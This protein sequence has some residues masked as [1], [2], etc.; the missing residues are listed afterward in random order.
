MA[1]GH[2]RKNK[3]GKGQLTE[4]PVAACHSPQTRGAVEPIPTHQGTRMGGR[5]RME[6]AKQTQARSAY[7]TFSPNNRP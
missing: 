7:L 1:G 4:L 5:L 6:C 2:T 3:L